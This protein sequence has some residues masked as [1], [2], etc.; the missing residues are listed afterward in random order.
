MSTCPTATRT[1]LAKSANGPATPYGVTPGTNAEQQVQNKSSTLTKTGAGTF[2]L[3]GA[4]TYTGGTTI[5]GGL[6]VC[7]G[8]GADLMRDAHHWMHEQPPRLL[9]TTVNLRLRRPDGL[10]VDDSE[11]LVV[12]EE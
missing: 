4:N 5:A 8:S 9:G 2:T 10:E 12:E 1:A 6:G 7:A 11:P 3:S